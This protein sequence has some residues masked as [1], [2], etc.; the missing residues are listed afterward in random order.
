M[1]NASSTRH[2]RLR[3]RISLLALISIPIYTPI[4]KSPLSSD[5][6]YCPQ[7]WLPRAP[8]L[9]PALRACTL[10]IKTIGARAFPFG[11]ASSCGAYVGAPP[12]CANF[13]GRHFQARRSEFLWWHVTAPPKPI[14]KIRGNARQNFRCVVYIKPNPVTPPQG[15]CDPTYQ[16]ANGTA[17]DEGPTNEDRPGPKG[18]SVKRHGQ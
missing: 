17:T 11:P 7:S 18:V 9:D 16:I 10:A 13:R 2:P 14:A 3:P 12:H 15:A 8:P 1:Y 6:A 5:C 4:L